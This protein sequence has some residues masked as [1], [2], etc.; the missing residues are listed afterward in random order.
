ML[1]ITLYLVAIVAAN[2]VTAHF[3][4]NASVFNAFAFI[5]LDLTARDGLHD[6]W[7]HDKLWRKMVLLIIS[8][9]ILSY[10][11]NRNAGRI[12]LA[13]FAAFALAG[14]ADAMLYHALRDRPRWKR[15]NGSNLLSS[16]VDSLAFPVGAFGLPILWDICLKQFGAKVLGGFLWSL[17]LQRRDEMQ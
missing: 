14:A 2:L 3:G 16:A 12:A 15:I 1:Y 10:A 5:G 4:P 11:L 8:G 9:S 13:S 7:R 6:A 17:V